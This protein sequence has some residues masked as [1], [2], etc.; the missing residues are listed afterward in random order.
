MP[1]AASCS[2][3]SVRTRFGG[4]SPYRFCTPLEAK[5]TTLA[6]V[7]VADAAIATF[8]TRALIEY[9]WSLDELAPA[10]DRVRRDGERDEPAT[11]PRRTSDQP[12]HR[13]EAVGRR[14]ARSASRGFQGGPPPWHTASVASGSNSAPAAAPKRGGNCV[15]CYSMAHHCPAH[16][17]LAH[18]SWR[19]NTSRCVATHRDVL[20]RRVSAVNYSR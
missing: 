6:G 11:Q 5:G 8:H 4:V 13:H 15:V 16:P 20:Q 1:R 9:R 2:A 10:R 14:V 3:R 17:V 18:P 12:L 7:K 19:C